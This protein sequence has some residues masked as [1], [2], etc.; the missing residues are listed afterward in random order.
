[1]TA[2]NNTGLEISFTADKEQPVLSGLGIIRIRNKTM[3]KPAPESRANNF[4][5]LTCV[6]VS[7]IKIK[8]LEN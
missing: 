6:G 8:G 4:D 2:K 3:R 7:A 1:V 5:R